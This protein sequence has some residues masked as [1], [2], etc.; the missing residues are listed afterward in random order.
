MW[1]WCD[2]GR[3]HGL[4]A[5]HHGCSPDLTCM[6]GA[7]GLQVQVLQVRRLS[8]AAGQPLS[9]Q[10]PDR[11]GGGAGT[12]GFT[13]HSPA[14]KVGRHARMRSEA[15]MGLGGRRSTQCLGPPPMTEHLDGL[16]KSA[17]V[18]FAHATRCTQQSCSH[19]LSGCT[20]VQAGSHAP[21]LC[22]CGDVH[23]APAPA[24]GSPGAGSPT[25]ATASTRRSLSSSTAASATSGGTS[26]SATHSSPT[27]CRCGSTAHTGSIRVLP[28]LDS[29]SS[30]RVPAAP[31][32]A[33]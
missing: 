20:S 2:K 18:F 33:G 23:A 27:T 17:V 8:A 25:A 19:Q 22:L 1:V 24:G 9:A 11:A 16:R 4:H 32:S 31:G 15:G 3:V 30:E 7:F 29:L 28:L 12:H 5:G 14:S 13:H 21:W 10:L 6:Y 26:C